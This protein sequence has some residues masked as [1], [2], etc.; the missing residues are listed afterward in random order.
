MVEDVRW[1]L[2][3][4]SVHV[5]E[6]GEGKRVEFLLVD[7]ADVVVVGEPLREDPAE[8]GFFGRACGGCDCGGEDLGVCEGQTGEDGE[9]IGLDDTIDGG[10]FAVRSCCLAGFVG[11]V[12]A[13]Q[14]GG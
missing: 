6:L 5:E 9:V 8:G 13:L 14:E 1:G 3:I 12:E 11:G 4:W 2:G 10:G 7:A